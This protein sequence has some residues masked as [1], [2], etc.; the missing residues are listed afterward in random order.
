M[1]AV[2]GK[3][4]SITA[5]VPTQNA[6]AL[7]LEELKTTLVSKATSL[8]KTALKVLLCKRDKLTLEQ[9][10]IEDEI[11]KCDE[12]IK[13]IK[14]TYFPFSAT[15]LS[16]HELVERFSWGLGVIGDWELQLETVLQSCNE[17]YP[18][19][20]LQE[21]PDKSACQS[22]KR[23]KLCEPLPSTKTMC[24]KLDD[25]CLDNN[26][27][28]PHYHVSLSED[29]FEAEVR[30]NETHFA[31][32]ICGEEKPDAEEAK[33]SA[34]A[35]LL[36]K[37]QDNTRANYLVEDDARKCD[38]NEAVSKVSKPGETSAE[39]ALTSEKQSSLPLQTADGN[40]T[41][42]MY[43]ALRRL[44][45]LLVKESPDGIMASHIFGN[46][47]LQ[48]ISEKIPRTKEELLEINGL[49][50]D[51]VSKYGD[52]LLETIESTLNE[53]HASNKKEPV[54]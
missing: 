23:V 25:I 40:L 44:R 45:L 27:V 4:I 30:I 2:A 14:G 37:L 22:N 17:T 19:R 53:Y 29:G 8:S 20:I 5:L 11:A 3:L 15:A 48:Q 39:A 10:Y 50:K 34:A 54:E 26:W 51:K 35:C 18:R 42:N 21:P 12:C 41:D 31:Y 24:Q 7:N 6:S 28:L 9:R 43:T 49:G 52:R 13:N 33:E 47:T 36:T 46:A 1:K 16:L 38:M 32:T